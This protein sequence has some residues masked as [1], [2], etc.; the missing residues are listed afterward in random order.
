MIHDRRQ[1]LEAFL[2]EDVILTLGNLRGS[3][4]WLGA[5]PEQ[6]RAGLD[7]LDRQLGLLEDR[8]RA[9]CRHL[10]RAPAGEP[11]GTGCDNLFALGPRPAGGQATEDWWCEPDAG[12]IS[13][14][15]AILDALGDDADAY[16]GL[17]GSPVFR[18]RRR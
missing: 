7:R 10:R 5:G 14:E 18:S 17:G 4:G 1:A 9:V 12:D 11:P 15:T 6:S 16:A 13:I 2:V 3:L 8:A